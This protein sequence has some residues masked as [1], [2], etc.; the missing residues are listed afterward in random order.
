MGKTLV[1]DDVLSALERRGPRANPY[2]AGRSVTMSRNGIVASSHGLASLAGVDMLRRGGGAMD[3]AVATAAVLAVVE[4]MMT[5]IGGDAFF[6]YYEA[7]TRTVFAL[8]GSGRSPAGLSA[9]QVRAD[10]QGSIPLDS[11]MSVTVP[12]AVDAWCEGMRRFGLL[13]LEAVLQP[14]IHYAANG[15]PVTEVVHSAWTSYESRLLIDGQARKTYLVEDRAPALGSLFR[16]P[17]LAESLGAIADRGRDAFYAGPIAE[18][19]ARYAQA[20]GG[21]LTEKDFAEHRSQWVDPLSVTFRGYEVLQI[22]PNGQGLGV[23]LMLNLLEGYDLA[24]LDHNS[25]EYLHLLVEAKKLAYADLHRWVADPA[26][27]SASLPIAELLSKDYAA[28][29]RRAIDPKRAAAAFDSGLEPGGDTVYLTAI[30]AEGNSVSFI[31]SLFDTFGSKKV[32]GETGI[33]LHNRGCGFSLEPGHPN[34]YAPCKRPFHSIIPGM[35]LSDGRLYLSYGV[36][37]GPMQPQGHVQFLLSHLEFGLGIQEA[38]D[39]PR[40]RHTTGTELLVEHGTPRSTIEA[41][42]SLGHTVVPSHGSHFGGAQAI[43]VDPETGTYFGASD[44]RKDGAAMGY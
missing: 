37:G 1:E 27:T 17:Q 4:P 15:F 22:P 34:E 19:I 24:S 13:P 14:A 11:W 12:G 21:H 25:P 8:N 28:D 41:L 23:L 30:D 5:G 35:V 26:E 38:I 32:G 42:R 44:P 40:W 43:L 18:E 2:R 33:L 36:M 9:R 29:R 6:L 20:E 16:S 3:A 7:S 31:N 10:G 39:A